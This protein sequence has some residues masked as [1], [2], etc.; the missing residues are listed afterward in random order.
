M[1]VKCDLGGFIVYGYT[2]LMP[3]FFYILIAS[4]ILWPDLPTIPSMLLL[5]TDMLEL[6][7]AALQAN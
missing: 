3:F 5:K 4:T 7:S 6:V 2:V 1:G